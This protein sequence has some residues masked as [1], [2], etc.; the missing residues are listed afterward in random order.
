MLLKRVIRITKLFYVKGMVSLGWISRHFISSVSSFLE[1]IRD[2]YL[3]RKLFYVLLP[4][5]LNL[6]AWNKAMTD[7]AKV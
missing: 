6:N 4:N 2:K 1:C 3:D 5:D 7:I